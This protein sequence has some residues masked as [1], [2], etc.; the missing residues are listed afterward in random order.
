MMMLFGLISKRKKGRYY[1]VG[2]RINIVLLLSLGLRL[3]LMGI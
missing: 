3:L 2:I 1:G